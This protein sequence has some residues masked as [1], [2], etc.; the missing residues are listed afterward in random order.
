MFLGS[1][2]QPF[3]CSLSKKPKRAAARVATRSFASLLFASKIL[4]YTVRGCFWGHGLARYDGR[5]QYLGALSSQA[6]YPLGSNDD[7]RVIALRGMESPACWGSNPHD[8]TQTFYGV[9]EA[10]EVFPRVS[11][12]RRQKSLLSNFPADFFQSFF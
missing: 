6:D 7:Q 10:N 3:M 4:L 2:S 1:W 11:L 5:L 8:P 12:E 9:R